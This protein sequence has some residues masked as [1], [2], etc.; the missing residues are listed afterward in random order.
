VLAKTA[1]CFR[2]GTSRGAFTA[3][4]RPLTP[5]PFPRIS[6][7]V[8]RVS[9]RA[10]PRGNVVNAALTRELFFSTSHGKCTI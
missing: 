7:A 3:A 10:V 6:G 4:E 9:A 1:A 5:I 8:A 2:T